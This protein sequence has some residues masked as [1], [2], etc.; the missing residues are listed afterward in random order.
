MPVI[1][2]GLKEPVRGIYWV[3][4]VL[5]IMKL[6]SNEGKPER[7]Q[8][9]AVLDCQ[10]GKQWF[11][12]AQ[13]FGICI[14]KLILILALESFFVSFDTKNSPLAWEVLNR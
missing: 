9:R 6:F 7:K 2:L 8:S 4:S 1:T 3:S 11:K 12:A 14:Y 13:L 5:C 10:I